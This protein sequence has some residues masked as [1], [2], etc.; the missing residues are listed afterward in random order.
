MKTREI[1]RTQRASP[2]AVYDLGLT[3]IGTHEIL[4][5]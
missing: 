4:Y 3:S 5:T 1:Q 2:C